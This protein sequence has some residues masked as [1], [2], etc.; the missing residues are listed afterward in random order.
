MNDNLE[1]IIIECQ[2]GNIEE[3]KKIFDLFSKKS[4]NITYRILENSDLAKDV[5]QN[6]FIKVFKKIKLYKFESSFYTWFYRILMNTIYDELRKN[7]KTENID[8]LKEEFYEYSSDVMEILT[9][10][11]SNLSDQYKTVFILYEI[12]GFSHNEISS[13]LGISVGTSKSNLNRAKAIL[14]KKLETLYNEII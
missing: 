2:S 4:Y 3:F 9:R 5:V 14:R 6:T 12:E 11:I 1:K 10:E 7:K 13:I 8:N